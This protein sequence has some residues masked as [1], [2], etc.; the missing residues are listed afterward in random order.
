MSRIAIL[1]GGGWGTALAILLSRAR[2]S[3]QV[4]IWVHD[5]ALAGRCAKYARMENI[6]RGR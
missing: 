5:P 3:H 1:G 4:S 2:E 6:C